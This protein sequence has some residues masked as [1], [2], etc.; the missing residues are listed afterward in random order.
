MRSRSTTGEMHLSASSTCTAFPSP[1]VEWENGGGNMLLW[2]GLLRLPVSSPTHRG[3]QG[4]D[5]T[6]S[7]GLIVTGHSVVPFLS[8][9]FRFLTKE[10]VV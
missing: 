9:R 4:G 6:T 7:D 10:T 5:P 2:S 3:G 8:V 1:A